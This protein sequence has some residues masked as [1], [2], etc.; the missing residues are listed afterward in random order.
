MKLSNMF[1][2]YPWIAPGRIYKRSHASLRW[3]KPTSFLQLEA[4]IE[5][6]TNICTDILLQAWRHLLSIRSLLMVFLDIYRVVARRHTR[7]LGCFLQYPVLTT[8]ISQPPLRLNMKV[9]FLQSWINL[10]S[11]SHL[12]FSFVHSLQACCI[13]PHISLH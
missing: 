2:C 7:I 9:S 11:C 3:Q 6:L 10:L 12:K 13:S 8:L 4:H 1:F 5:Y